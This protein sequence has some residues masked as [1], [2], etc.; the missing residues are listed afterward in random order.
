MKSLLFTLTLFILLVQ[1]VSGN[2][3]VRKCANKTGNCRSTCRN[4]EKVINPPTGKCSKEKSCCVLDNGCSEHLMKPT[5]S[6]GSSRTSAAT[7]GSITGS[8]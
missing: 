6:G 8:L 3:Y 1:L 5:P 4:G 2:W 7:G